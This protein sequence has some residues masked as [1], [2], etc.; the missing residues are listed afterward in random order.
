M[1]VGVVASALRFLFLPFPHCPRHPSR[2]G[3]PSSLLC[4]GLDPSHLDSHSNCQP[5]RCTPRSS[6]AWAESCRCFQQQILHES[7]QITRSNLETRANHQPE[8]RLASSLQRSPN[9]SSRS[10]LEPIYCPQL[11]RRKG[12]QRNGPVRGL[13][14]REQNLCENRPTSL[15]SRLR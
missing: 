4:G 10:C 6:W 9:S 3:C 7:V 5:R 1:T 12:H 14:T 11:A 13:A 8:L 2:L 15:H